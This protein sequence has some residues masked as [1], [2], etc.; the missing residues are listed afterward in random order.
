MIR[1]CIIT[2]NNML[3]SPME[4]ADNMKEQMGNVS[5]KIFPIRQNRK[6]KARD[7]TKW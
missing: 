1:E 4:Q 3:R 2:M 5:R 6:G 7:C